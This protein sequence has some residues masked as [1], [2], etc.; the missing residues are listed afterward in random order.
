ME[1]LLRRDKGNGHVT[2]SS[3]F[4]AKIDSKGRFQFKS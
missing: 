4:V 1:F 3:D 2:V